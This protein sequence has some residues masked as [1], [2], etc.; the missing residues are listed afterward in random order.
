MFYVIIKRMNERG[1]LV[2]SKHDTFEGAEIAVEKLKKHIEESAGPG[3][4]CDSVIIESESL[5]DEHQEVE[6]SEY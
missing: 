6:P 2:A 3:W 5:F 4:G 1:G